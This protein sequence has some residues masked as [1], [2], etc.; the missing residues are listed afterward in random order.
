MHA[1]IFS[2]S[3]DEVSGLKRGPVVS[4]HQL[5]LQRNEFPAPNLWWPTTTHNSQ[6]QGS[7]AAFCPQ[8]APATYVVHI[9]GA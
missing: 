6:I 1:K 4:E 2:I 3:T 9:C 5:L 8:Q 7:N